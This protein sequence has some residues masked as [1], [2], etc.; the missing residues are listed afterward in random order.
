MAIRD[1]CRLGV[2][3]N[4]FGRGKVPEHGLEPAFKQNGRKMEEA[5]P[6]GI[7]KVTKWSQKV[8]KGS[9]K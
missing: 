4:D 5:D 7:K 2:P 6:E 8:P 1:F 3:K 9:Q